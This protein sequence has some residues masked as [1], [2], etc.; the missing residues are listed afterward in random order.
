[1]G[2]KEAR[3]GG[4]IKTEKELNFTGVSSDADKKKLLQLQEHN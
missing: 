3:T 2:S 4:A 1:M